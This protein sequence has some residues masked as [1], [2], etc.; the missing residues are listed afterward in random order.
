[1]SVLCRLLVPDEGVRQA[2]SAK[3]GEPMDYIVAGI[4]SV[5]LLVY[6]IYALLKPERF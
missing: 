5:G 6:L 4:A 3:K 1:M 2:L